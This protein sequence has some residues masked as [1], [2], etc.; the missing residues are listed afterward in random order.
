MRRFTPEE[1]AQ[2]TAKAEAA[3]NDREKSRAAWIKRN[4]KAYARE[5]AAL[6]ANRKRIQDANS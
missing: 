2:Q 1:R 6:N 4:P 3:K 5:Q